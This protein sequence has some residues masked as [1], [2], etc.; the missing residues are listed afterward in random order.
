MSKGDNSLFY[1]CPYYS[2]R[3]G[4][5]PEHRAGNY[6]NNAYYGG[7]S[8]NTPMPPPPPPPPG[9]RIDAS[10]GAPVALPVYGY[11]YQVGKKIFCLSVC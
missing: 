4:Y 1:V 5:Y 11:K 6:Y 10:Y 9:P 3:N 8:V 7:G 2:E